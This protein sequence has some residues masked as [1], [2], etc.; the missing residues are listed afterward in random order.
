MINAIIVYVLEILCLL[1]RIII[2][3]ITLIQIKNFTR[4]IVK[5]F[6]FIFNNSRYILYIY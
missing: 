5:K 1:Y 6:Y 4:K 2:C 3:P